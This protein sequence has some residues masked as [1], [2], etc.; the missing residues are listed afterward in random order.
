MR[1][2]QSCQ[3]W[4]AGNLE[5]QSSSQSE[6][7]KPEG[8][9]WTASRLPRPQPPARLKTSGKFRKL[10]IEEANT[11]RNCSPGLQITGNKVVAGTRLPLQPGRPLPSVCNYCGYIKP[12][13]SPSGGKG[14]GSHVLLWMRPPRACSQ[15]CCQQASSSP[16]HSSLCSAPTGASFHLIPST[17]PKIDHLLVCSP[18]TWAQK[19][20]GLSKLACCEW[21]AASGLNCT[22][23]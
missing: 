13:L 16:Q 7:H 15:G 1:G 3:L 2:H 8:L 23:V 17:T 19:G 5:G 14:S 20:S 6:L 10:V 22:S 4:A 9:T 11:E 12:I 21:V 18:R